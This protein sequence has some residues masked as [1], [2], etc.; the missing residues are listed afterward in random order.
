MAVSLVGAVVRVVVER[1]AVGSAVRLLEHNSFVRRTGG[2][3]V[4]Y[5]ACADIAI[6]P[7]EIKGVKVHEKNGY[8]FRIGV[9]I[10]QRR[11]QSGPPH[12]GSTV[13]R[14]FR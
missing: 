12:D 5:L 13:L 3:N 1:L 9:S 11:L 6:V 8:Q 7:N 10:D 2:R 14:E 4:R